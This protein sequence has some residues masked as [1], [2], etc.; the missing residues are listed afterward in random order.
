MCV[1]MS[2]Y[3][4][5]VFKD[6]S[7]HDQLELLLRPTT[8]TGAGP[9]VLLP[10]RLPHGEGGVRCRQL[11]GGLFQGWEYAAAELAR[12]NLVGRDIH[13]SGADNL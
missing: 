3:I 2:F 13:D 11:K 9:G 6:V 7:V 12:G 1:C 8:T 10:Y 5:V 4:C